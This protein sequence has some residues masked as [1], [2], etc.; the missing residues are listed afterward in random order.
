MGLGFHEIV[1][2]KIECSKEDEENKPIKV[3]PY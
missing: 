3:E 1:E 2:E